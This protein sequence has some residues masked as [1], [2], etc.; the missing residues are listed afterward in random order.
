MTRPGHDVKLTTS[1]TIHIDRGKVMSS[2]DYEIHIDEMMRL[3]ALRAE[4]DAWQMERDRERE[5]EEI[6]ELSPLMCELP[7]ALSV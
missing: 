7:D 1:V 3:E 4:Y 6:A 2:F 5:R